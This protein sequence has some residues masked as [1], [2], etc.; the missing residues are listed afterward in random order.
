M[1]R[2]QTVDIAACTAALGTQEIPKQPV[3]WCSTGR[4]ERRKGGK[5]GGREEKI[6]SKSQVTPI[7]F[8][9]NL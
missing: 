4:K 6:S 7:S 2:F 1:G 3:F 8:N 9:S 5:E